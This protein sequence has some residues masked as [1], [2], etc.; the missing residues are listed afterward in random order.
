ML[1]TVS[2]EEQMG[3]GKIQKQ[4]TYDE[5]GCC[6]ATFIATRSNEPSNEECQARIDRY[7]PTL[8]KKMLQAKK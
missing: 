7:G 1:A 3:L 5:Q 2:F 6:V 4:K 8:L